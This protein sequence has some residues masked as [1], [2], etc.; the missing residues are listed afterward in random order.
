MPPKFGVI[1]VCCTPGGKR[2]ALNY[3]TVC[4]GQRDS[5]PCHKL[6]GL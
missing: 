6:S 5:T 3:K 1:G 4:F 2:V